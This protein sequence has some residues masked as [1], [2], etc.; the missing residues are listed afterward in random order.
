M[1]FNGFLS[2]TLLNCRSIC[3]SC[4]VHGNVC[5]MAIDA[6]SISD[7]CPVNGD[8]DDHGDGDGHW[9]SV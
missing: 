8:G 2:S 6:R 7:D 5:Q 3:D 9:L 4:R 1:H